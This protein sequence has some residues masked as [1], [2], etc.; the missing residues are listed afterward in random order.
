MIRK[1]EPKDREALIKMRNKGQIHMECS[2]PDIW[3]FTDE[4]RHQLAV[5]IDETMA[6]P[7]STIFVAEEEEKTIGYIEGFI[8]KRTTHLPPNVGHVGTSYVEERYRRKGI[9]TSLVKALC[10]HFKEDG[11]DQVNLR[12]VIG[13]E[14][15]E[16]F[17][18][19]FGFKPR[20]RAMWSALNGSFIS[21]TMIRV[22]RR[23]EYGEFFT[24]KSG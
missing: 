3:R 16:R 9:G 8:R 19:G 20:A 17:W 2:N 21:Q 12:Y 5:Q 18:T 1:A 15:A 23:K 11:V 24:S 10:S 4:G 14:E 6:N 22:K 13:N 7:D